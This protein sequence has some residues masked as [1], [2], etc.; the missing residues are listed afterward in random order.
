[1]AETGEQ[2]AINASLARLSQR[3]DLVVSTLAQAGSETLQA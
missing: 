2:P 1:M 3:S